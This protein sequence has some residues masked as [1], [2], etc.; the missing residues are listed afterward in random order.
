M[1]QAKYDPLNFGDMLDQT[2]DEADPEFTMEWDA[3]IANAEDQSDEDGHGNP[4]PKSD[5]RPGAKL[6]SFL[7]EP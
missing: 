3:A 6:P 1:A 2:Q 4:M 5:L 7:R